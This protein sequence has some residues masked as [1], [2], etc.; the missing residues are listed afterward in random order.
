MICFLA[1]IALSVRTGDRPQLESVQTVASMLAV[2][3]SVSA[4]FSPIS[5]TKQP[6]MSETIHMCYTS[7]AKQYHLGACSDLHSTIYKAHRLVE[8]P[9]TKRLTRHPACKPAP[10]VIHE[11]SSKRYHTAATH[12]CRL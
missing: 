1:L 6:L 9:D 8:H 4:M 5:N 2:E 3:S 12:C 7:E 10:P 11:Y